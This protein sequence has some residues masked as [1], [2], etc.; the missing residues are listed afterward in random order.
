M[1]LHRTKRLF[2]H[3]IIAALGFQLIVGCAS[4]RLVKQQLVTPEMFGAIGNGVADDTEALKN[5]FA[6]K[7]D[8]VLKIS[9]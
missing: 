8:V 2:C 5:A 1:A 7:K 3:F 4:G 9:I 6:T